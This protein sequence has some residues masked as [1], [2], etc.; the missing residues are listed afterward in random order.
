MKETKETLTWGLWAHM[1]AFPRVPALQ[2]E[3][4]GLTAKGSKPNPFH[5]HPDVAGIER[6]RG[7]ERRERGGRERR[8]GGGRERKA[9]SFLVSNKTSDVPD[10]S[11]RG[12]ALCWKCHPVGSP[13]SCHLVPTSPKGHPLSNSPGAE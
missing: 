11:S 13:A 6:G 2:R 8:E 4:S 10:E 5:V 7:E 3:A 12:Q 9:Y 1:R